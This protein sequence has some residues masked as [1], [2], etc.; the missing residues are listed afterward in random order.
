MSHEPSVNQWAEMHKINCGFG[1]VAPNSRPKA[2][3]L[4]RNSLSSI[5]FIGLPWP[6]NITGMRGDAFNDESARGN[7]FGA[8]EL[9]GNVILF[10]NC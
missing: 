6:R 8:L 7:E 10:L 4:R 1:C 2:Y 3:Q 9:K 5:A